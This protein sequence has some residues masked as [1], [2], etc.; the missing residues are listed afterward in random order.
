MKRLA[1]ALA[2]TALLGTAIGSG[3]QA[4]ADPKQYDAPFV[5]TGS[6][7]TQD[8]MNALAGFDNGINYTPLQSDLATG[9]KQFVS[10]DATLNGNTATCIATRTGGPS[11]NRPFGSGAGRAAV[12]ATISAGGTVSNS[13]CGAGTTSVNGQVT[14][15]RSSS[16]SG[17]GGTTMAYVTFARDALTYGAYRKAGSPVVDLSLTELG[18]IFSAGAPVNIT[19]GAVVTPVVGC[20][21]QASS[22]TGTTWLGK[23][24]TTPNTSFCDGLLTGNPAVAIGPAEE[25]NG[26]NLVTRGDLADAITPGTQVVI[27]FSVGN[28]I[29]KANLKAPGGEP[30][31]VVLGAI[32]DY[33]AGAQ[34]L[35]GTRPNLVGNPI[36]YTGPATGTIMGRDLYNVFAASVINSAFGNDALKQIFKG[37]TS[38][39]CSASAQA[40]IQ[41]FGFLSLASTTGTPCGDS[42]LLRGG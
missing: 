20:G 8:V 28:Y 40:T 26:D 35:T 14:G 27:G 13:S 41:T 23:V 31:T 30:T 37:T 3:G 22:G 21:I 36:Y 18:Q 25:N 34:P 17:T 1:T 24:T 38:Q 39:M 16:V 19:R 12:L 10:W 29:G 4:N 5:L 11:F 9:N 7:T 2:T 32:S 33:Q 42:T 6:D 15:A